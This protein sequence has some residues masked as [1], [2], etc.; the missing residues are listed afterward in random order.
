MLTGRQSFHGE[1]VSDILASVLK[2]EPNLEGVP[3]KVRPLLKRCLEKDPKKRLQAI[4]D[5]KLLLN[6]DGHGTESL[7]PISTPLPSRFAQLP[8]IAAGVLAVVAAGLGFGLYRATRPAELK[9]LV[10]LDVDLGTGVS[11]DSLTG[12]DTILSPDG[13]RLVY[14]SQRAADCSPC[15]GWMPPARRSRC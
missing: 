7:A 13:T 8:W 4:G 15:S 2:D 10:R 9:P 6:R 12:A 1:T 11:L 5:W 14:V 3:E